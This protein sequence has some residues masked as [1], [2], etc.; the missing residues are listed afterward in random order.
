MKPINCSEGKALALVNKDRQK[1]CY[2]QIMNRP[3]LDWMYTVDMISPI[4]DIIFEID[5]WGKK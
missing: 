5:F 1:W 4:L 2:D 3:R